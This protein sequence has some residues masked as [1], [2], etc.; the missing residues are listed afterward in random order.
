MNHQSFSHAPVIRIFNQPNGK[1]PKTYGEFEAMYE[2]NCYHSRSIVLRKD[3]V[4]IFNLLKKTKSVADTAK[5]FK[6][7]HAKVTGAAF[8][9]AIL[10]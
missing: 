9:A 8:R 4:A 10:G 2:A 7:S 1:L 3:D 6:V 5:H